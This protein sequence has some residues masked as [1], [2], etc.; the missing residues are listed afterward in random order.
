[1]KMATNN[2]WPRM[3]EEE[4][5]EMETFLRNSL[6]KEMREN[7]FRD[8]EPKEKKPEPEEPEVP[9]EEEWEEDFPED[10]IPKEE[11][12]Y[13]NFPE[14]N[15]PKEEKW[16]EDFPQDDIPMGMQIMKGLH[17]PRN[18]RKLST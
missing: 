13:E 17:S 18:S 9:E 6:T 15:I 8:H 3:T 11:E 1:M 4:L 10:D 5:Q 14:D 2:V 16:C 12:W 7:C